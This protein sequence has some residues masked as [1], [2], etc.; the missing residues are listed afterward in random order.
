[1]DAILL[2]QMVSQEVFLIFHSGAAMIKLNL[3]NVVSR[4]F[5]ELSF[6]VANGYREEG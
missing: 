3:V 1:M 5:L 6:N 4:T 2:R